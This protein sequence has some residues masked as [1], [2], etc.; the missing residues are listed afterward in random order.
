MAHSDETR[1]RAPRAG[2]ENLSCLDGID[3]SELSPNPS[4]P[5]ARKALATA[6][7]LLDLNYLNVELDLRL[8]A[9]KAIQAATDLEI[10]EPDDLA[11]R[12][13]RVS[14]NYLKDAVRRFK[15]IKV[16]KTARAD[17]IIAEAY[18]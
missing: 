5:Q 18:R 9:V 12:N 15:Q 8:V 13:I 6:P 3:G 4:Q 2:P 16:A 11:E 7:E 1:P 17:A 14:V 10:G